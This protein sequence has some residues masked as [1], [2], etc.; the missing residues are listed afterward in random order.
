M[1]NDST[2]RPE[3]DKINRTPSRND[4]KSKEKIENKGTGGKGE[5]R[6]NN[7]ENYLDASGSHLSKT[8]RNIRAQEQVVNYEP[9]KSS[10]RLQFPNEFSS[11]S[12]EDI[13]PQINEDDE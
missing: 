9:H 6:Y 2:L 11:L 13:L 12:K 3:I 4:A 8:S 10:Q 1:A 7:D 5:R